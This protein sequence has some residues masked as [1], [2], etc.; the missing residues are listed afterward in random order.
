MTTF[1]DRYGSYALVTG[2]SGGIG[3]EFARQL[4]HRGLNL[5]LVARR[6]EKLEELAAAL[7]AS[8]NVDV[9]TVVLDLLAEDAIATLLKATESVDIGLVVLNAGTLIMG[10]FLDGTLQEHTDLVS[11]NV[12]VPMQ[13]AHQFGNRLV[14][15]GRGGLMFVASIVGEHPT[16]YEANYAASKAYVSSLGRALHVELSKAGIDVTVLAPGLVDTPMLQNAPADVTET[17]LSVTGPGPV[18]RAAL[19]GLGRRV[20]VIPGALNKLT[21][22]TL[23]HVPRSTGVRIAGSILGRMLANPTPHIEPSTSPAAGTPPS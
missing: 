11:L 22:V 17:K 10:P 5:V 3:E 2:A 16:P 13:L 14:R 19:D 1:R 9:K 18:V 15:R 21:D 20:L 6:Q 23:K 12:F 7:T 8:A 4:A